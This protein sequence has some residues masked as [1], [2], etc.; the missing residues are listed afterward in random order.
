MIEDN[1]NFKVISKGFPKIAAELKALWGTPKFNIY[2]DD[3]E[4]DKTGQHRAGFPQDVLAA[5]LAIGDE[6]DSAF[7]QLKPKDSWIS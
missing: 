5:L 2:L 3:L 7:P 4:Q 1:E 6:H